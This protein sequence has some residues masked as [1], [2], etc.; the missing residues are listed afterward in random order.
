MVRWKE[1]L[2]L[3]RDEHWL[4]FTGLVIESTQ[5]TESTGPFSYIFMNFQ[6]LNI[7]FKSYIYIHIYM[8]IKKILYLI[9]M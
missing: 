3:V 9:S 1:Y 6:I 7:L 4:Y 2:I 5:N 8:W